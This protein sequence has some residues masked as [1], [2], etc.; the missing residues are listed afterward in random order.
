[1]EY[2]VIAALA[3]FL[4][5]IGLLMVLVL[6]KPREGAPQIEQRLVLLEKM[7]ERFEHSLR[8]EMSRNRGEFIQTAKQG[9]EESA[10]S[11]KNFG[12]S[13]IR[14][15]NQLSQTNESRLERM[16]A[17]V[18]ERLK[19]LQDDNSKKLDQMRAV[20]DE[21]LQSTLEKRLG[22]SFKMVSDRLEM[23]Y[24]GLGEM[25]VLASDVGDLKKVLTNVKSRGTWG[26]IQLGS[27]LEQILTA[28]QYAAN[29]ATQKGSR[30]RV[31][32][33]IRLPGRDGSERDTVW[34]PIDAKFPQ[35]DYQRLLDAQERGD[36]KAADEAARGLETRIKNSAKDIRDKYLSP[37]ET[38][39][40]AVMYLPTEG[41]YAEVIRRPGLTEHLQREFRVVAA[42]PTTL[43]ALLNSLQMGFRT[44]AIERRSSEVWALLGA[45][46]TEFGRFGDLLEKTHQKIQEAGATIEDAARKS[47]TIEKKLK[48]V[49]ELPSTRVPGLIEEEETDDNGKKSS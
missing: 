9:R 45:V 29:V 48:K 13:I 41:L 11:L 33:A 42:G 39:D 14:Q 28:E 44:L 17:T 6:R 22:E 49:Q 46:K 32:F 15:L 10:A 1:M 19:L 34:L 25:Q 27:L 18:E 8:E 47:R 30:E 35:E 36:Q 3:F 43:A 31:E 20:V 2:L 7:L 38:T 37:P 4:I 16:R 21:K 24:R 40:F 26:E 23:V 5:T 12:D